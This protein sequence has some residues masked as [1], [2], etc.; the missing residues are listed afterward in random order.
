MGRG[1]A[2]LHLQV[3]H[4]VGVADDGFQVAFARALHRRIERARDGRKGGA[5]QPARDVA[6]FVEGGLDVL[7]ADRVVEARARVF[8]PGP[9]QVHG[10]AH[11]PGQ[12]G[13]LVHVVALEL[14]AEGA[15]RHHHVHRDRFRVHPQNL[16]QGALDSRRVL[17]GGPDFTAVLLHP[18]RARHGF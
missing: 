14:P 1:V 16:A 6:L 15:A 11:G 18:H 13:G 4:A 10:R 17:G 3:D 9:D 2:R 7:G 12:D 8:L 5:V